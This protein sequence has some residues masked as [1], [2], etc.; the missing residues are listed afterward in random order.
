MR[1]VLY[2][3]KWCGR[4]VKTTSWAAVAA[5]L[6]TFLMADTTSHVHSLH[7]TIYRTHRPAV[8][9]RLHPSACLSRVQAPTFESRD[10]QTYKL[11]FNV[12]AEIHKVKFVHQGHRRKMCQCA[13]LLRQWQVSSLVA[14]DD[15]TNVFTPDVTSEKKTNKTLRA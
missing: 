6:A 4:Y 10:L 14:I 8:V 13:C 1:A 3:D 9:D 7:V 15:I 5:V 11:R 12:Q 2:Q